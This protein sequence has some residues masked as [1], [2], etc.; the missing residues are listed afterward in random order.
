MFLFIDT[1]SEPSYIALFTSNREII[2]EKKWEGKQREFD[3]LI[4]M[5]DELL[6]ENILIYRDLWG[7]VVMVWP[8]GFTGTRVTA[9]VANTLGYSFDIPLFPLTVWDFFSYQ[10]SPLP[11]IVSIT[12]KEALCWY[13][14][15]NPYIVQLDQLRE[16]VY[17]SLTPI[18][19]SGSKYTIQTGNDYSR[20]ISSL[21][22][23]ASQKKIYPVY[24]KDP[25][26][27]LKK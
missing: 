18:D 8:G 22:L 21:P 13:E 12:K 3:T 7:I 5:I 24:A 20:V 26:I 2:A 23:K 17:M 4:E 27:T 19:F 9:L 16:G 10:A 15:S 6:R 25:N 11:W 1:L 14:K